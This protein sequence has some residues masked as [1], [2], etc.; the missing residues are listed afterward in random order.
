MIN[1]HD[2]GY[3]YGAPDK[4]QLLMVRALYRLREVGWRNFMLM[5]CVFFLRSIEDLFDALP[6]VKP[7]GDLDIVGGLTVKHSQKL[8]CS[9]RPEGLCRGRQGPLPLSLRRPFRLLRTLFC[10]TSDIV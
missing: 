10:L 4:V 5:R 3:S 9:G 1:K 7:S 6:F 2:H 8:M